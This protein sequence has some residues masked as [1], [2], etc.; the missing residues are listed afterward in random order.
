[1][2]IGGA[3]IPFQAV[4][5]F[6]IRADKCSEVVAFRESFGPNHTETEDIIEA[7]GITR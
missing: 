7:V 5:H 6:K 1:M 3:V 4:C 2:P